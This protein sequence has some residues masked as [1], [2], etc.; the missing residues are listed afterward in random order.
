[1]YGRHEIING[2]LVVSPSPYVRHARTVARMFNALQ[3]WTRVHGGEVLPA[4]VDLYVA[5][6]QNLVPDVLLV[7]ADH[8]DRIGRRYLRQ[9]PDLVVEVSSSRDSRSRDLGAKRRIY[10]Q[11]G[12]PEY[13]VADMDDG[14]VLAFHPRGRPLRPTG[15]TRDGR[16]AD[17]PVAR[18]L[19]RTGRRPARRLT[20]PVARPRYTTAEARRRWQ[21]HRRG[22]SAAPAHVKEADGDRRGHGR[23]DL[24]VGPALGGV[25]FCAAAGTATA[26]P[27]ERRRGS[28]PPTATPI[29]C[30]APE[31]ERRVRHR[32]GR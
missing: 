15:A 25:A 12:V 1:A 27:G 22:R 17:Q 30:P 5:E 23:A 19:R 20:A 9:P 2:E 3:G 14:A 8:L 4:S 29:R 32:R 26:R 18:R 11:F 21:N 13:W 6:E 24:V 16:H 7:R 31:P 10:A 28:A